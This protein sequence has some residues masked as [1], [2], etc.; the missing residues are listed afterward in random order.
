MKHVNPWPAEAT[1]KQSADD[2]CVYKDHTGLSMWVRRSPK[3][4]PKTPTKNE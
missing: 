1:E 4:K 2:K 3:N